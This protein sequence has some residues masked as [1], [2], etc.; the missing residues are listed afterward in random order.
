MKRFGKWAPSRHRLSKSSRTPSD[1]LVLRF[2]PEN[3]ARRSRASVLRLPRA[4]ADFAAARRELH[5]F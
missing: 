2:G 3:P 5:A 1:V 4:F